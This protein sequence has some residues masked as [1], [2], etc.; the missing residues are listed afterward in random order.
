MGFAPSTRTCWVPNASRIPELNMFTPFIYDWGVSGTSCTARPSVCSALCR[1]H[2]HCT[3]RMPDPLAVCMHPQPDQAGVALA[4]PN[5]PVPCGMRVLAWPTASVSGPA[6]CHNDTSYQC[7][8]GSKQFVAASSYTPSPHYAWRVF[9]LPPSLPDWRNTRNRKPR[10][11][12]CTTQHHGPVA[13]GFYARLHPHSASTNPRASKRLN[14]TASNHKASLLGRG[15]GVR[16]RR[17]QE[18]S[19]LPCVLCPTDQC[20][21]NPTTMPTDCWCNINR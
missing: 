14:T 13:C 15:G 7:C 2:R 19:T 17:K 8:I 12:P 9:L 11:Q 4:L 6:P 1:W 18:G 10:R 3:T 20:V 16:C 21:N 5:T